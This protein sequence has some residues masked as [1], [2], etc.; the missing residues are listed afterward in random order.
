MDLRSPL[1]CLLLSAPALAADV[2]VVDTTPGSGVDF[3]SIETA[4][5]AAADGDVVLVRPGAYG[6]SLSSPVVIDGKS[7]V[8]VADGAV[9]WTGGLMVLNLSASQ[10]FAMR[11][12]HSSNDLGMA[13]LDCSGT[14]WVEDSVLGRSFLVF[15]TSYENVAALALLRSDFLV[16][17]T[18]V[19]S[20]LAATYDSRFQGVDLGHPGAPYIPM[21][22]DG[23]TFFAAGSSFTAA[24][25][26]LDD[27]SEFG[28][29]NIYLLDSV[30]N[31]VPPNTVFLPGTA[32]SYEVDATVRERGTL[33]ITAQGLPDELVFARVATSPRNDFQ[34]LLGFGGPLLVG[35]FVQPLGVVP[36]SG[37][38]QTTVVMP[39][40]PAGVEARVFYSQA[41]FVDPA[42]S[43]IFH[44]PGSMTVLLDSAL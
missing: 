34:P 28:P 1:A 40:L 7:V 36:P 24:Y 43:S 27:I 22:L 2:L 14:V 23:G 3:T 37:V 10:R 5:A 11:G 25:P 39:Q 6:H 42:T 19:R 29:T 8:L 33:T 16:G 15:A 17:G 41:V 13:A 32:R 21:T 30:A 38:F 9:Q 12:L 31:Q 20:S 35:G 4:L 26:G 18:I 44:G